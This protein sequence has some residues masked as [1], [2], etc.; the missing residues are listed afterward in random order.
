M[1]QKGKIF[2]K[3]PV[4]LN[5]KPLIP[6]QTFL[7]WVFLLRMQPLTYWWQ[8]PSRTKIW[9]LF[10]FQCQLHF[11]FLWRKWNGIH[12]VLK[13]HLKMCHAAT[14]PGWASAFPKYA[15]IPP[16][17]LTI[18]AKLTS[19]P[20]CPFPPKWE[21]S[22][23]IGS[24]TLSYPNLA[25]LEIKTFL[26]PGHAKQFTIIF[27]PLHILNKNISIGHASLLQGGIGKKHNI[28]P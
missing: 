25:A 24:T 7:F 28:I 10:G 5:P 19:L 22:S 3:P 21:V 11:L 4:A 1:S 12:W 26:W 18:R 27:Y 23:L 20:S 9:L 14:I 15:P 13:D 6:R 8:W 16:S 2:E 17:V